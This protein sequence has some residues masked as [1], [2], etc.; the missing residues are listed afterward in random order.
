MLLGKDL[1]IDKT[2][3]IA[4]Q[5][6]G[7]QAS[8]TIELTVQQCGV[9]HPVARQ[10]QQLNYSNGNGCVFCIFHAKELSRRQLG[11][12]LSVLSVERQPVKR[13]LGDW[14]EMAAR[15]AGVCQRYCRFGSRSPQ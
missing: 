4:M 10:L 14:C 15:S 2:T 5:Q 11:G 3:A 9:M 6:H 12:Q 8:S 1:K 13:R 7:K